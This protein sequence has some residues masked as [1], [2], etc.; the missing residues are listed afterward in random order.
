MQ[1][2]NAVTAYLKSNQLLYFGL[3]WNNALA[4][5][6][7]SRKDFSIVRVVYGQILVIL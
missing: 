5:L 6:S 3:A 1:S 2:Q 4:I 7:W